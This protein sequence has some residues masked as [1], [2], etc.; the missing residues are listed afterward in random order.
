MTDFIPESRRAEGIGYWGMSTMFA[1]AGGAE[2]R[3]LLLRQGMA[4][5]LR[6]DRPPE[7]RH[8]GHRLEPARGDH[9]LGPAACAS[10]LTLRGLVEWR[11]VAVSLSLFLVSF[12]YGGITSFVALFAERSGVTPKGLFFTV[13]AVRRPRH[14]GVRGPAR[15]RDRP[16]TLR[17]ALLRPH[18]RWGWGCLAGSSSRAGMAVAAGRLRP[19]LRQPLPGLRGP[20]GE[21]RRPGPAGGGLRGDPVRLRR[22]HRHRL[23]DARGA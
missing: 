8:G 17:G 11:V 12:G 18:Q 13:F 14:P 6:R 1:V 21:T 10:P 22:G 20:R 3:V 23:H 5:A 9:H 19:R 15:G 7:P 16:P 4:R 2:R